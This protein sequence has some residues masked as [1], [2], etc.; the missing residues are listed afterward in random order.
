[1]CIETIREVPKSFP[2]ARLFKKS[3]RVREGDTRT[4][5]TDP[6]CVIINNFNIINQA[7]TFKK[8]NPAFVCN[9]PV[10]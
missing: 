5:D 4:E 1:M 10:I 8:K 6:T 9:F 3:L 2:I 7:D